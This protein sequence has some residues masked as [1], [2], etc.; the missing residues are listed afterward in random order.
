M[1][2]LSRMIVSAALLLS[3][4]PPLRAAA[5]P[6]GR[7][8]EEHNN[9]YTFADR[10]MDAVAKKITEV[11]NCAA[12][13]DA[14]KAE[15]ANKK[16]EIAAQNNGT[17]PSAYDEVIALKS[18]RVTQLRT[19]CFQ[20]NKD[21]AALIDQARVAVKGIEPPSSSGVPK[22]RERLTSLVNLS[23]SVAKSLR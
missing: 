14:A 23:N 12:R 5:P 18:A 9:R 8:A 4:A 22:R 15:L 19:T 17:V 21:V 16:S 11:K 7:P 10:S 20:L 2:N 3:A 13:Y 1:K 6:S